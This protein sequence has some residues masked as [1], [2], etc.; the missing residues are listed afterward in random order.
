VLNGTRGVVTH[1]D[2][3]AHALELETPDGTRILLPASYLDAHTAR[4]G[5]TVDH[6]YAITGHKSQGMTTGRAFV[7]GT[8]ELYREWGYVGLSRGRTENRLY[9][10]APEPPERDEY[11]SCWG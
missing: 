11:E 3:T 10:V 6:G 1:V 5:A 7:L 4:G 9:L 8:E 2:A